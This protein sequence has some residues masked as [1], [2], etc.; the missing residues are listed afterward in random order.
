MYNGFVDR[1]NLTNQLNELSLVPCQRKSGSQTKEP[2]NCST[3]QPLVLRVQY[4]GW[5]ISHY[6]DFHVAI[7]F[8]KG[9]GFFFLFIHFNLNFLHS[10][11]LGRE[12]KNLCR[13]KMFYKSRDKNNIRD[14]HFVLM[15]A[16]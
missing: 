8:I 6:P 14:Y 13:N 4:R 3:R 2:L 7:V 9:V 11:T 5:V 10:M 1:F 16:Q 15:H 12:R